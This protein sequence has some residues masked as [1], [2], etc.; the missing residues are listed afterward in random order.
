MVL[1]RDKPVKLWGWAKANRK[2]EASLGGQ[3]A[4]ATADRKGQWTVELKPMS[5]NAKGQTLVVKAGKETLT[6]KD[7]LIGE[8]ALQPE[9]DIERLPHELVA[10]LEHRHAA[11]RVDIAQELRLL[12]RLPRVALKVDALRGVP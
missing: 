7:V 12:R 1:Q 5:A 3:T 4:Q 9:Q 8:V 10:D 6:Y 2:I 11:G